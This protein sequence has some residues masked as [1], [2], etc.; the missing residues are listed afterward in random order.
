LDL[1]EKGVPP[2]VSIGIVRERDGKRG[3]AIVLRVFETV[4]ITVGPDC[5]HAGR[6]LSIF[7]CLE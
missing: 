2:G 4:G 1:L 6:E 5:D 7:G 3:D